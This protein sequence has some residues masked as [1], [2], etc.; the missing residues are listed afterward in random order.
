[1]RTFV[2]L[3]KKLKSSDVYGEF[4]KIHIKYY[5]TSYLKVKSKGFN[6]NYV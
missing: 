1:M 3:C 6:W 4:N 5:I 2:K